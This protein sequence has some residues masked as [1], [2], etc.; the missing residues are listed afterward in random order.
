MKQPRTKGP[1]P[2]PRQHKSVA[3]LQSGPVALHSF[4]FVSQAAKDNFYMMILQ[5]MR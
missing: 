1:V 5:V 2:S 4:H 3:E